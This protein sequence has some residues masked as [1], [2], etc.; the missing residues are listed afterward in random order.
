MT[1]RLTNASLRDNTII[2]PP[3]VASIAWVRQI[4]RAYLPL[5]FELCI[6]FL[7]YLFYF[8]ILILDFTHIIL[9]QY[10][11]LEVPPDEPLGETDNWGVFNLNKFHFILFNKLGSF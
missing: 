11:V 3:A 5:I 8:F 9:Y 4:C 10:C 6:L 2:Y 1:C 7:I